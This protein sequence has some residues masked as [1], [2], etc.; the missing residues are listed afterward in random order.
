[1]RGEKPPLKRRSPPGE[2]EGQAFVLKFLPAPK[3][4]RRKER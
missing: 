1:M 2:R 3:R 4:E